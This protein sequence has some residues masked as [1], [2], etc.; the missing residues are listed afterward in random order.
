ML[1]KSIFN[2]ESQNYPNRELIISFPESDH[3]TKDLVTQLVHGSS[4]RIIPIERADSITIGEAKNDAIL[5]CNGEYIC[6]WDDDDWYHSARVSHQLSQMINFGK[7][8]Q[9]SI[10]TNI[11]LYDAILKKA[12]LSAECQLEG[13]LLCR[14]KV[15]G[16]QPY[17]HANQEEGEAVIDFMQKSKILHEISD[18]PYLYVHVFHGE[19]LLGYGRFLEITLKSQILDEQSTEWVQSLLDKNI[20]LVK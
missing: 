1:L 12:Y 9:G 17:T 19:N 15:I 11:L 16:Q 14:K 13:T 5:Q 10:L 20:R 2:F 4:I 3:E 6:N 18:S 8:S 7:F